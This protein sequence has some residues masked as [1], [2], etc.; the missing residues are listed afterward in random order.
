M[1]DVIV[2]LNL[3][4]ILVWLG[5]RESNAI[6]AREYALTYLP[7]MIFL[8]QFDLM[9]QYVSVLEKTSQCVVIQ[10]FTTMFHVFL[11]YYFS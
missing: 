4:T 10:L 8:S 11:T 1:I 3:E 7:G 2:L 6:V 5:Q 9:R